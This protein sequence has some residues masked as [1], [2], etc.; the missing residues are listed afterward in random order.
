MAAPPFSFVLLLLAIWLAPVVAQGG[1]VSIHEGCI[2]MPIIHSKNPQ[3]MMSKRAVSIPLANHSDIAYYAQRKNYT[4]NC[5]L[6]AP[7]RML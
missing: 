3:F 4:P 6:Q 7:T 1:L 2:H 5:R